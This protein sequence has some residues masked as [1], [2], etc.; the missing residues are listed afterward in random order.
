M[1]CYPIKRWDGVITGCNGI[2]PSPMIYV[3]AEPDLI[4][5]ITKNPE[6]WISVKGTKGCYDKVHWGIFDISPFCKPNF[7]CGTKFI[8][9]T[10]QGTLWGGYPL[11]LGKIYLGASYVPLAQKV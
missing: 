6:T 2:T 3:Q 11:E 10:L 7:T 5:F 9:I 8:T 4:N 1:L